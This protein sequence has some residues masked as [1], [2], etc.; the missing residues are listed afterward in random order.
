MEKARQARILDA[1]VAQ[2]RLANAIEEAP[3]GMIEGFERAAVGQAQAKRGDLHPREHRAQRSR[4]RRVGKHRFEESGDELDH[5]ALEGLAG[6]RDEGGA[7]LLEAT[8]G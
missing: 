8:A 2:A 1:R 7:I 5:L 4:Q 3:H 6:A